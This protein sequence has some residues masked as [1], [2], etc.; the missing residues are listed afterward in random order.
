MNASL[1][2][3]IE[4]S[5]EGLK[6]IINVDTIIGSPVETP[7]QAVIIPVSTASFGFAAG[8]SDFPVR[9][10][11][12]PDDEEKAKLFAGGSGAGVSIKPVAF[13]VVAPNQI[14]LIPVANAT[15]TVVDKV[16]DMMP[17]MMDKIN[18]IFA[19]KQGNAEED[20]TIDPDD[21]QV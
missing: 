12:T 3:L 17:A 4:A 7:N 9:T 1:N 8:G 10:K 19:K 11:K 16:F 6:G 2:Q 15:N 20:V 13:L 18:Q 5:L 21:L 14:K